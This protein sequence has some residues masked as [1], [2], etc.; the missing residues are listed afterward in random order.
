MPDNNA[1]SAVDIR[2]VIAGYTPA[3]ADEAERRM[4]SGIQ[5]MQ[6]E[7]RQHGYDS[8]E[9]QAIRKDNPK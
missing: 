6:A 2:A 3:L 5:R 1:D 8:A 9:T 4:R 7:A